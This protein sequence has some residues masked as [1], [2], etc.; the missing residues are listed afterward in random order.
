MKRMKLLVAQLD[1][2]CQYLLGTQEPVLGTC[3]GHCH[4]DGRLY[5]LMAFAMENS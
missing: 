2:G 1:M 4:G 5:G 3:C